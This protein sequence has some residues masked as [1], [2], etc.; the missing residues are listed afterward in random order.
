[1]R[2]CERARA[3][4]SSVAEG[5]DWTPGLREIFEYR[6]LGIKDGELFFRGMGDHFEIWKAETFHATI[7]ATLNDWLADKPDDFDPLIFLDGG[8]ED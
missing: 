3:C 8:K 4:A 1:M 2:E 7:G 5:A 6:D